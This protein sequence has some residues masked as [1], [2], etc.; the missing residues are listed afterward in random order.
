MKELSFFGILG[1]ELNMKDLL[2]V[3]ETAEELK[4]SVRRVHQLIEEKRLPAEKLG[5]YYVIKRTD[6][7]LVEERKRT[8][9]PP[10]S[11]EKK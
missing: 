3:A 4:I 10:S 7:I 9:R 1:R 8:G 6:L 2:T 11:K 5:S